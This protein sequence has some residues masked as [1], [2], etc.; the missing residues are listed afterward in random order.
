MMTIYLAI[1][2]FF[3][4]FLAYIWSSRNLRNSSFKF[5]LFVMALFSSFMLLNNLGYIVKL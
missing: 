1:S 2:T 3:F 5:S 4:F